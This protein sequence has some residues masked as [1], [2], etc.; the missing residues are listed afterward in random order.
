MISSIN[1]TA[2]RASS[3]EAKLPDYIV[4]DL[5]GMEDL[6]RIAKEEAELAGGVTQSEDLSDFKQKVAEKLQVC[7]VSMAW[8]LEEQ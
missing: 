5:Q 7:L 1:N 8:F 3:V 6:L 4:I 2:L